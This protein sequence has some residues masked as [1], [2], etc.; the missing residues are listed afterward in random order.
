M[1]MRF[2]IF[3]VNSFFQKPVAD[4]TLSMILNLHGLFLTFVLRFIHKLFFDEQL[5]RIPEQK[6]CLESE[7]PATCSCLEDGLGP[8]AC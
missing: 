2:Q 4:I 6:L 5:S 7:I 1:S 3:P 8:K